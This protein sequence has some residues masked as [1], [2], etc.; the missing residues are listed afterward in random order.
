MPGPVFWFF[1]IIGLATLALAIRF[2]FRPAER[3]LAILRPLSAATIAS[4]LTAVLLGTANGLTGLKWAMERA[5]RAGQPVPSPV[6]VPAILG[7]TI[8]S[9]AALAA[10][11]ALLTVV[12]VLVAVGLRR[13]AWAGE[14]SHA[15]ARPRTTPLLHRRHR[16]RGRPARVRP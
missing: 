8:E 15:S 3:T 5:A 14:T 13:Q 7:G 4:A 10:C 16:R 2:A 6:N 1:P 11:A 9:L 12:W